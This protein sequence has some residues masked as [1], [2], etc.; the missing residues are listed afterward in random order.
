[1]VCLSELNRLYEWERTWN[2]LV[3]VCSTQKVYA[4]YQYYLWGYTFV[5]PATG[6]TDPANDTAPFL[7]APDGILQ[8][9]VVSL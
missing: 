3:F 6:K 1:M 9:K 8:F 5:V 2:A 7:V 4:S